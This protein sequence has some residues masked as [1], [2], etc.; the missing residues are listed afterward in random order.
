MN[1]YPTFGAG[2]LRPGT[3]RGRL[4]LLALVATAGWVAALTVVFN[5]ALTARLHEQA[6]DLLRTRAAAVAA[7]VEARPDGRLVVR[8][9]RND[10]ALDVGVWVYQGRTA[11][12]R[13]SGPAALQQ[14]ADALAGHTMTFANVAKPTQ[15]RLYAVPVTAGPG[16]R[17]VGTVVASV[18]LDPYRTT[19]ESVFAASIALALA[20]LGGVYLLTRRIVDRA[21]RPVS[22]MSTQAAQWSEHGAA[23]RFGTRGRPAELASLAGS[24]DELLDRL[25]AVL[26]HER[27]LSAELSHE[28]RT[29]LARISAETDWL[30]ARP[31]TPAEQQTAHETIASA[32]ADMRRICETLLKDAQAAATQEGRPVPGRCDLL[33]CAQSLARRARAEHPTAAPVTVNGTAMTAGVS[34]PVIERVLTPL[35]DNARRYAT[36]AV[37]LECVRHQGHVEVSVN[38]DGPGVPPDLGEA[39]FEAGRRADPGDGHPGAGLGLPLARRLARAAGGDITLADRPGPLGGARFVVTLPTG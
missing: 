35:L 1:R 27:H 24:L 15:I 18:G 12:E 17:Q 21:L 32:A 10:Q 34:P 36:H 3:L 26:R 11:L 16:N 5:V 8:E 28:L 6:D 20:L 23:Q 25:A 22:S 14:R 9:P 2:R 30:T 7:T 29:P 38:D 39:V 31:R 37:R 19:A 13:P 33:A 4:A